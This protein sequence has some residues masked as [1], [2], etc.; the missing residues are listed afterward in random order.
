MG[1]RDGLL[2][3]NGLYIVCTSSLQ[4]MSRQY[5][6]CTVHVQYVP[7][8]CTPCTDSTCLCTTCP[9][10]K[11]LYSSCPDVTHLYCPCPICTLLQPISRQYPCQVNTQCPYSSCPDVTHLYCPCPICT[12]LQPISRQYPCQVNTQCPVCISSLNPTSK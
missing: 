1:C 4:P 2:S 7:H 12:L 6:F 10:N 3:G 5:P 11:D 9:V 8:L